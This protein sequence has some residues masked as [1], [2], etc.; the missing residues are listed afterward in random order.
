MSGLIS[1]T[2]LVRLALPLER[3]FVHAQG[4]RRVADNLL[5]II[6]LNGQVGVGECTP[7]RYLTGETPDTVAEAVAAVDWRG[8]ERRLTMSSFEDSVLAIEALRLS[9]RVGGVGRP[10]LAAGCLIELALLDAMGKHF[11]RPLWQVAGALGLPAAMLTSEPRGHIP[12]RTLD[13][14]RQVSD[15]LASVRRGPV[16]HVKIKAGRDAAEDRRRI[17]AVR[18]AL[19]P[20]VGISIDANMAWGADEAVRAIEA[21]EDV[22]VAWFEEPLPRGSLEA[23]RELRVRTGARIMLDESLCSFEDGLRAVEVCDLFN[24]R[25]SKCGGLLPSLRLAELAAGRGLGFQLGANVG[26]AGVLSAA[27]R[28]FAA[29]LSDLRAFEAAMDSAPAVDIVRENLAPDS[30]TGLCSPLVRPGLGVTLKEFM[31]G[32]RP[33]PDSPLAVEVGP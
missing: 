21:L 19:G 17:R 28:Q 9:E 26:Q 25:I 7:R 30:R 33:T 16:V 31:P 23:Y 1:S 6:H 3:A 5:L 14:D 4:S 8:I 10:G 18:A 20:A 13:L 11:E 2:R 29:G 24:I 12:V 15:F 27:G 22:G 32:M